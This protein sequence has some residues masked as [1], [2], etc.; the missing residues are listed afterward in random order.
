MARMAQTLAS[1]SLKL[2]RVCKCT[3]LSY[4]LG[5]FSANTQETVIHT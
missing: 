2:P 1:G 5:L 4:S 3:K